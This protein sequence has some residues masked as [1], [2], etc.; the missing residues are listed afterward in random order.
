MVNFCPTDF[1]E[2]SKE[3]LSTKDNF[4]YDDALFRTLIS[5]SYYSA[6]LK[7]RE[8]VDRIN[9]E[10]RKNIDRKLG[11]HVRIIRSILIVLELKMN[12]KIKDRIQDDFEELKKM[13]EDADYHFHNAISSKENKYACIHD[14]DLYG[15]KYAIEMAE[16]IIKTID[17]V[18]RK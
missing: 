1:L 6:L 3:L 12:Q 17:L 11:S 7:A 14:F 8:A 18:Q 2:F 4:L 15:A 5:R 16:N 13:R 9:E 10:I